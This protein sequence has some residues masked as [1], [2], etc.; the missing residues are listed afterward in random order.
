MGYLEIIMGPMFSGKTQLLI[1]KYNIL[2]LDT[3]CIAFNY[4]K[5]T[6]YGENIIASHDKKS[7]PSINI[8][9]LSQI[10]NHLNF[11]KITHILI[12]E[13][14]FFSD[15][16]ESIIKLI[17]DYN[18]HVIICGLDS[19]FKREKF[20]QMWDLIPH[21]DYIIKLKGT[22]NNCDNYSLFTHRI[23]KEQSQ[24]VIGNDN[25]IPL[26]RKCYIKYN[27]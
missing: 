4:Y 5:D 17:E 22:C 23:S 13:A 19:D 1:K 11:S 27:N 14:Q 25:Y 6:R 10:F 24:E 3:S 9:L 8:E 15:L 7:I 20:G 21:A 16:K 26:C 18:K 2:S 12:N